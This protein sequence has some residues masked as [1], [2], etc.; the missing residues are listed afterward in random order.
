MTSLP[1]PGLAHAH[2]PTQH[3]TSDD[4]LSVYGAAA[5]AIS[6]QY[7]TWVKRGRP[8][9]DYYTA[10]I[11]EQFAKHMA[12]EFANRDPGFSYVAFMAACGIPVE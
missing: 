2:E 4:K 7:A 1:N 12:Q 9:G 5:K 6:E 11:I 10:R 3:E 8:T